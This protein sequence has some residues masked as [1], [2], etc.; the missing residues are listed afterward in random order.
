MVGLGIGMIRIVSDETYPVIVVTV[1]LMTV[2][3]AY[4]GKKV[5]KIGIVRIVGILA[6][7]ILIGLGLFTALNLYNVI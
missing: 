4:L 6:G 7:I 5:G 2:A 3:G 1:G